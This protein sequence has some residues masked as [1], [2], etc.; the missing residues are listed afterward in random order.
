MKVR[1]LAW[2]AALALIFSYS[3]PA[4]SDDTYVPEEL[5]WPSGSVMFSVAEE[6]TVGETDS[7]LQAHRQGDGKDTGVKSCKDFDDE[8]CRFEGKTDS[9][10]GSSVLP[11]C[12]T[13]TDVN[14]IESVELGISDSPLLLATY[15]S[16]IGG[17]TFAPKPEVGYPGGFTTSLWSAPN[18]PATGGITDYAVSVR[19]SGAAQLNANPVWRYQ[20]FS[21]N[22]IPYR[23]LNGGR[24]QTPYQESFQRE[25]GSWYYGIG[26]HALECAWS[27][28]GRCGRAQNFAEQTKVRLKLRLPKE[29]GG[30]FKGR[31]KDPI[32]SITPFNQ[33][34]NL[35]TIQ[36]EPVTVQKMA[37]A[38]DRASFNE[39]EAQYFR[40]NG[41]GGMLGGIGTWRAA[42]RDGIFEY[43]SYFRDRVKDTA[44]G[45]NTIWSMGSIQAGQGSSCL[46]GDA[47]VM[48]IV[49]TNAMGYDGNSPDYDSGFLNYNVGGLHYLPDGKTEFLG[50][51]DLVMRSDVARCLYGFSKAP[52]SATISV[53]GG[54]S[55]TVATTVV[56][57]K[58]GWLKLAAYGFTFSNK[59]I[60]VKITQQKSVVKKTTIIC[61]TKTKPVK[62]K[63]VTG[64]K[65]TC[66]K[67]FVRK[68]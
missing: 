13:E 45:T 65:P 17:M 6:G 66:P 58:N 49:S 42:S 26:G 35:F 59:E 19:L 48:G 44:S 8:E 67:G 43:I 40:E 27:D 10:V 7:T 29:I 64:I 37:V 21:A 9:I 31:M 51:Y 60:K 41:N 12:E 25:D 16:S 54:D 55:N 4:Q 39:T 34:H 53:S 18:A 20:A 50:T 30:W 24:Y 14:C 33:T 52:V 47:Q 62:T 63:K 28:Q 11:R 57:E 3:V 36:A 2:L 23:I 22:V 38:V 68:K 32:I 1:I 46:R 15:Q 5:S 61:V 56:S